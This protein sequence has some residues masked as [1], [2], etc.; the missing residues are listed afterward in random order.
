MP[1]GLSSLRPFHPPPTPHRSPF[2]TPLPVSQVLRLLEDFD[3][4]MPY[5][6]TGDAFY[7]LWRFSFLFTD[8]R[9]PASC[10]SQPGAPPPVPRSGTQAGHPVCA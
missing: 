7:C 8:W 4:D 5:F 6:I 2:P 10:R 3:H 1:P 9:F